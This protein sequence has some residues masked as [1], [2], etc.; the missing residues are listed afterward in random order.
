M[1]VFIAPVNVNILSDRRIGV[2]QQLGDGANVLSFFVQNR[3]VSMPKG[4]VRTMGHLGVFTSG[5]ERLSH[6]VRI[7][8]NPTSDS[9]RKPPPIPVESIQ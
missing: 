4:V 3:G 8:A 9:N 2:T 7:P 6:L 1:N 5:L